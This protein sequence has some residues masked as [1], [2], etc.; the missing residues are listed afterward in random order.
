ME[1]RAYVYDWATKSWK[2][3]AKSRK[4]SRSAPESEP[5]TSSSEP[6]SSEPDENRVVRVRITEI[7]ERSYPQFVHLPII[8]AIHIFDEIDSDSDY[9]GDEEDF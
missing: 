3:K 4:Q 5:P 2:L 9:D 1:N 8:Q 6:E 7:E